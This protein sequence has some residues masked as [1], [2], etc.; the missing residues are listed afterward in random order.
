MSVIIVRQNHIITL[1]YDNIK[2]IFVNT[3]SLKSKIWENCEIIQK[4]QKNTCNMKNWPE[5]IIKVNEKQKIISI[6]S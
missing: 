5:N 3:F 1:Y 6:Y 4:L 2:I